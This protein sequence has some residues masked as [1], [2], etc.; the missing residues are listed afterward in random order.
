MVKFLSRQIPLFQNPLADN[1]TQHSHIAKILLRPN[2]PPF[3]APTYGRAFGTFCL[4]NIP[5][6]TPVATSEGFKYRNVKKSF[7]MV[8][9]LFPLYRRSV[10]FVPTVALPAG[11]GAS[12]KL[13]PLLNAWQWAQESRFVSPS[14]VCL[15]DHNFVLHLFL[16][17]CAKIKKK[18][19][20]NDTR[21]NEFFHFSSIKPK[22][23]LTLGLRVQ[24]SGPLKCIRNQK[25]I[26]KQG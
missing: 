20:W 24:C 19:F 16:I 17:S 7:P 10:F 15:E 9:F 21:K 3:R 25:N 8:E 22:F 13:T 18:W 12:S 6:K 23:P 5:L 4:H 26:L 2:S 11:E 1:V 14:L